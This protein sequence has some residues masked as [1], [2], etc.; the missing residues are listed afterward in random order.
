[1]RDWELGSVH[2]NRLENDAMMDDVKRHLIKLGVEFNIVSPL[3][4]FIAIEERDEVGHNCS[5]L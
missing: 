2:A 4:S 3:T 1:M 5:T